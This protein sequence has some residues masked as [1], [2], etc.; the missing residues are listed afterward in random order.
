[1]ALDAAGASAAVV[2]Q[3]PGRCIVQLGPVA[4]TAAWLRRSTGPLDEGELLV[5]V[6]RG[7]V[8]PP[9][10]HHPERMSA[11]GASTASALWERTLTPVA[12]SEAAWRWQS[13]TAESAACSSSEL[14]AQCV[15]HLRLAHAA[16]SDG[17]ST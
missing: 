10:E 13:A 6:W 14:A 16:Y 7:S 11:R 8:A 2:R 3:S 5:I 1:M 9:L 15:E 12:T 4:L 17:A